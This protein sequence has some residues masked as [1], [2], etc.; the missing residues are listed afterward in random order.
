MSCPFFINP[1]IVLP[2][3][4]GFITICYNKTNKNFDAFLYGPDSQL[5]GNIDN[6][7]DDKI[8]FNK[9]ILYI[10]TNFINDKYN[11]IKEKNIWK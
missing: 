11:S 3:S 10:I 8:P 4:K 6:S 9:F 1:H 7:T 5:Y 2:N